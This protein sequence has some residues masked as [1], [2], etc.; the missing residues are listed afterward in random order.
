VIP[1]LL[2]AAWAADEPPPEPPP[3][4]EPE[5]VVVYAEERVRQARAR[6]ERVL[7]D[8]GYGTDV[9][10]D[11]GDHVIMRH[12]EPWK[13][14][15]VLWDDGWMEVRRQP[16]RVEGQRMPWARTD[17][18]VAWAGCLVWPWLCV[19]LGG[20]TVGHRKWLGVETG[21]VDVAH[22]PVEEWGDRIADLATDRTVDG[23]PPRLLDLWE[24]G[25]PLEGD[26]TLQ[27]PGERRAEIRRYYESR[28]D[29]VWGQAVRDAI[30]GFVY[31]VVQTSET[32]YPA[33]ELALFAPGALP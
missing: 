3:E 20:G 31:A 10:V 6:V 8:M 18:A 29:T 24:R 5:V 15:V 27:T 12:V 30:R 2:R 25:V 23:L 16:L 1:L 9:V 21:A 13:G 32:P 19:K 11:E 26:A 22:G 17:S 28:T 7:R 14:E 33:E 4:D